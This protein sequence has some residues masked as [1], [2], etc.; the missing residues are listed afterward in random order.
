MHMRRRD[1]LLGLAGAYTDAVSTVPSHYSTK[2]SPIDTL[3]A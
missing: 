3:A 2:V 1:V